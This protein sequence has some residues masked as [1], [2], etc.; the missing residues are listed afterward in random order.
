[1]NDMELRIV[2]ELKRI[3][4]PDKTIAAM[5][6]CSVSLVQI[7]WRKLRKEIEEKEMAEA[8]RKI[9]EDAEDDV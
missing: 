8:L 4:T 3:H 9:K 1:M 7:T 6:R 5:L 2:A